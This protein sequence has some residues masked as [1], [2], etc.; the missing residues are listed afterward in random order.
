MIHYEFFKTYD[1]DETEIKVSM[2]AIDISEDSLS[3][4]LSE[5]AISGKL[6]NEKVQ[7]S[8]DWTRKYSRAG[9]EHVLSYQ[10]DQHLLKITTRRA[11]L[12]GFVVGLHRIRGFEGPWQ[13]MIYGIL[14]DVVGISLI[15][16]A[17]T[18][19]IL[20]MKMLKNDWIA[21]VVLVAG[22]LYVTSILAYFLIV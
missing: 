5:N 21:W 4:F 17:V 10:A 20:W 18:G 15:L 12:P 11:K 7:P 2:E 1:W 22:F 6:I 3:D 14:L 13:Y 19:A 16:F 8:G 9:N